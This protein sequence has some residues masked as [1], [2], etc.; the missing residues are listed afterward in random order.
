MRQEAELLKKACSPKNKRY[1]K[2]D[3]YIIF[4]YYYVDGKLCRYS[5]EDMNK[6]FGEVESRMLKLQNQLDHK[7]VQYVKFQEDG[8]AKKYIPIAK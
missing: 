6:K 4:P 7:T 5:E 3:E 1:K 2:Y 8:T